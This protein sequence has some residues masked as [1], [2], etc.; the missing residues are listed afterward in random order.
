MPQDE[1]H[2]VKT[3]TSYVR[4]MHFPVKTL[5]SDNGGNFFP[6]SK[7]ACSNCLHWQYQIARGKKSLKLKECKSITQRLWLNG[8]ACK[9]PQRYFSS[10]CTW[11]CVP[12]GLNLSLF[13]H[14]GNRWQL[15]QMACEM[16]GQNGSIIHQTSIW[17]LFQRN[18][19][20]LCVSSACC[21]VGS[22]N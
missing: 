2:R 11:W 22:N 16:W 15:S 6:A 1:E 12:F 7:Q 10:F 17:P 18:I 9:T 5:V 21:C 20:S 4:R 8:E 14:F 19:G 3:R 13:I